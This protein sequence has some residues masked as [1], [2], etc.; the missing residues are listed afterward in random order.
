LTIITNTFYEAHTQLIDSIVC[1]ALD[2]M[3]VRGAATLDIG[4]FAFGYG[5]VAGSML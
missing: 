4:D 5:G 1:V 3:H 2:N